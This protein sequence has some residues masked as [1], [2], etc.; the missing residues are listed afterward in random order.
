MRRRADA[1]T[2]IVASKLRFITLPDGG[3]S[4]ERN[5]MRRT[6]AQ[7][8]PDRSLDKAVARARSALDAPGW[9]SRSSKVR[10]V[11]CGD[12]LPAPALPPSAPSCT[13]AGD[14]P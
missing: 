14:F 9:E 3:I 11:A 5:P 1:C 7:R 4:L 2:I 12:P 13:D 10:A 6:P 8:V